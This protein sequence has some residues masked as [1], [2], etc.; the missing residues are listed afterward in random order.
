VRPRFPGMD[1]WLEQ[2]GLWPDVHK[3]LITA[4]RDDLAARIA[5][6]YYVGV[7]QHTYITLAHSDPAVVR[8]DGSSAGRA[9]EGRSRRSRPGR[10]RSESW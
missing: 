4:I 7:E 5:P 10:P 1:S 9:R 2:T 6:R 8:P 3:S